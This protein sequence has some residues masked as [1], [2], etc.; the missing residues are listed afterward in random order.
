MLDREV[1]LKV[2]LAE[3]VVEIPGLGEVLVRALSRSELHTVRAIRDDAD[4]DAYVLA[5]AIVAP[6]L[7]DDDARALGLA[8]PGNELDPVFEAVNRLS[9]AGEGATKSV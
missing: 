3:E 5:R 6:A 9:D 7:T 8:S 4:R 2:R 1:L